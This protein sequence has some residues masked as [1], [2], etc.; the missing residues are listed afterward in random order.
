M[1]VGLTG[2]LRVELFRLSFRTPTPF[3]LPLAIIPS[4]VYLLS[5]PVTRPALITNVLSLSFAF[6]AL[7]FLKLDSFKTGTILLSG[8]FLYD[9][10]WVFGTD[11]VRFSF[12]N[13]LCYIIKD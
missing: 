3:L 2:D 8:L 9:I 4:A 1:Y 11:V 6:N 13:N 10:W 5:D 12:Q 7:C